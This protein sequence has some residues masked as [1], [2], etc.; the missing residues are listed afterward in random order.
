MGNASQDWLAWLESSFV[1]R[2]GP[3]DV[4]APRR[5]GSVEGK[6]EAPQCQKEDPVYLC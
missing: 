1:A 3:L 6:H 4:V 2:L 5:V